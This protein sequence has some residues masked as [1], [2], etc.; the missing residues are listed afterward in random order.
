MLRFVDCL[1]CLFV[2]VLVLGCYVFY[3]FLISSCV[4]LPV[5]FCRSVVWLLGCYTF[6]VFFLAC[7][8]FK[9]ALYIEYPVPRASDCPDNCCTLISREKIKEK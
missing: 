4:L 6:D 3:V 7:C 5:L 1:V 8:I 9:Y 2:Y